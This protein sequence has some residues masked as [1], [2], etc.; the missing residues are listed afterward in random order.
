MSFSNLELFVTFV[1]YRKRCCVVI[2]SWIMVLVANIFVL[3]AIR[4][5]KINRVR[6]G[7][8][9]RITILKIERLD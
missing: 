1:N 5:I 6:E 8:N 9:M 3:V 2:S 7:I 4:S